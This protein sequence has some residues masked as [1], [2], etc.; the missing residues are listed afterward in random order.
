MKQFKAPVRIAMAELKN[1]S[2][3]ATTEILW[4]TST[5]FNNFSP[6]RIHFPGHLVRI[7]YSKS[8]RTHFRFDIPLSAPSITLCR[9]CSDRHSCTSSSSSAMHPNT[10]FCA[11][12]DFSTHERY[13]DP[14]PP[15][16]ELQ[17]T[18]GAH[19]TLWSW[20]LELCPH[21]RPH[22]HSRRPQCPSSSH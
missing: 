12:H 19:A 20:Q 22:A 14:R 1:A 17:C 13:D 21:D 9:C 16:E 5:G 18:A 15:L 2:M 4:S 8:P 7:W 10:S 3:R 6:P 11:S